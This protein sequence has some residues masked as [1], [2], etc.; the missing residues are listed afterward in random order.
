MTPRA[1]DA[2]TDVSSSQSDSRVSDDRFGANPGAREDGDSSTTSLGKAGSRARK[3]ASSTVTF[4]PV[5]EMNT[6]LTASDRCGG[7]NEVSFHRTNSS[8]TGSTL[9]RSGENAEAAGSAGS[10]GQETAAST[11]S[12]RSGH[13]SL[14]SPLTNGDVG[15][16]RTRSSTV[17]TPELQQPA[18][19]P[20]LIPGKDEVS[21]RLGLNMHR[22]DSAEFL[23]FCKVS[24]HSCKLMHTGFSSVFNFMATR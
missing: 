23:A 19:A 24:R 4:D 11:G 10:S 16:A 22:T 18:R 2:N 7:A 3:T 17:S 13:G 6:D 8:Q 15:N 21:K 9:R 1:H 20:D 14:H 12:A 5:S